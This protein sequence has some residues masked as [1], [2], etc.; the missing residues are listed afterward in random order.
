[1]QRLEEEATLEEDDGHDSG[2]GT[3]TSDCGLDGDSAEKSEEA[4]SCRP[5]D[6]CPSSRQT[7]DES[8]EASSTDKAL[9][10]HLDDANEDNLERALAGVWTTDQLLFED[11]SFPAAPSSLFFSR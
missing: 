10:R 5:S 8:L 2:T 9:L 3:G 7:D 11:P 4:N 6:S 1:M